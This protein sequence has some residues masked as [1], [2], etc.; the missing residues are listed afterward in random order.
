MAHLFSAVSFDIVS[1][2][3]T[4]WPHNYE[5]LSCK[6]PW[7]PSSTGVD[8]GIPFN[9]VAVTGMRDGSIIAEDR[10]YMGKDP[11]TY[12]FSSEFWDLDTLIIAMLVTGPDE[13]SIGTCIDSPCTSMSIDNVTLS[14][15]PLPAPLL[16][17]LT[18]LGALALLGRRKPGAGGR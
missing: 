12:F 3:N 13:W 6:D 7:N 18:G 4:L 14:P 10:F 11:W 9:N 5:D 8:C 17:F 15:I 2:Q 1:T 16:L